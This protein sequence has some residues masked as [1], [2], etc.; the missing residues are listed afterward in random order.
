MSPRFITLEGID[1]AG[2]SSHLDFIRQWLAERHIDAVFTREPGGTVLA[3]KLRAL[4]LAP[5]TEVSLETET[6]LMFASRQEHIQRVIRPALA[7]GRWVVSDRFTDSSFA[8]QGGGRGLPSARIA[9]LEDWVQQGLQP[10]LTLLFDVPIEVAKA[11]MAGE[12]TLD[13]IEREQQDFHQRARQ[14]YLDRAAT[15][16]RFCV[17][18]STRPLA[19]IRDDIAARLTTLLESV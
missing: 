8:Y 11:R 18:D 3:E 19:V 9:V 14:A 6:L 12:R 2:K 7:A 15:F 10:D 13:R 5:E 1:G 4:L 17:L 16:P